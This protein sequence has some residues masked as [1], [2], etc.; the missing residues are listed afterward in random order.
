MSRRL[1]SAEQLARFWQRVEQTPTHWLWRAPVTAEGQMR[2]YLGA[3]SGPGRRSVAAQIL[4][5]TLTVGPLGDRALRRICDEPLCIRPACHRR[6]WERQWLPRSLPPAEPPASPSPVAAP[7]PWLAPAR[8]AELR[9]LADLGVRPERLATRFG[10][11]PSA[12]A[13][14]LRGE[15]LRIEEQAS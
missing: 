3:R 4:A 15:A 6:T 14:I 13:R 1:T 5:W 12:V 11:H 8:L 10:L 7:L 2:V 9:W